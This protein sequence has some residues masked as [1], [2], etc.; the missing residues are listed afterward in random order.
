MT[1]YTIGAVFDVSLKD[2]EVLLQLRNR[3]N[4]QK[5]K[6]NFPGGHVEEGE[7]VLQCMKREFAEECGLIIDQKDWEYAGK[8]NGKDY[9]VY[10][11]IHFISSNLRE[12]IMNMEDQELKWFSINNLPSNIIWNIKGLVPLLLDSC[13]IEIT[14]D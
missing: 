14:Y 4:W 2:T 9:I 1:E 6:Y 8:I 7:D 13:F 3:P 12:F 11:F 10:I 5:G